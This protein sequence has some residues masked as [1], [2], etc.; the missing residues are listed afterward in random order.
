MRE[1]SARLG[2]KTEPKKISGRGQDPFGYCFSCVYLLSALGAYNFL[3]IPIP[4]IA[5]MLTIGLAIWLVFAGKAISFP[6]MHLFALFLLWSCFGTFYN[7]IVNDLSD[8]LPSR[9]STGYLTYI[10]L[11]F[12]NMVG[13]GATVILVYHVAALVGRRRFLRSV[14]GVGTMVAAYALYIYLAQ[15]L[16]WWEPFRNRMGTG[17]GVQSTVFSYAF[18]RAMG[19]FREPS[20][21]AEWLLL[22]F[23]C[24]L[25]PARMNWL[26]SIL[27]L[28]VIF[29]TGSL[30]GIAALAFGL[31][32][33]FILGLCQGRIRE[34]VGDLAKILAL[35]GAAGLI[36]ALF[37]T[38]HA[39]YDGLSSVLWQRLEP[40]FSEQGF[41]AGNRSYIYEYLS[42]EN[43]T[44]IGEGVGN[45]NIRFSHTRGFQAVASFLSL[46][47]NI[48]ISCGVLGFGL[49]FSFMAVP[50]RNLISRAARLETWLFGAYLAWLVDFT[51]HS[52]EL[53]FSFGLAYALLCLSDQKNEQK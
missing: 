34:H 15:I 23:F 8:L 4:W 48:L 46:Y 39:G 22:P 47:V 12:V 10:S 3:E 53:S 19:S 44:L 14:T 5:A 7:V 27:I 6:G 49:L 50:L 18:H 9:A 31:S 16:N 32:G 13:F 33:A 28:G 36:F 20:H 43:L 26:R 42:S 38:K 11:R 35:T 21:L 41:S 24:S 25:Y 37:V 40:M 29:L 52:E 1:E 45:A 2:P 17:G 51:M 30:S